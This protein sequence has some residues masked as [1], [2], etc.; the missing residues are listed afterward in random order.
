[1]THK[2]ERL[3]R[4]GFRDFRLRLSDGG[5]KLQVT[6]EQFPLV[7]TRREDILAA[8]SPLFSQVVLDLSPRI[9]VD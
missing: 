5:G 7:Q 2:E 3:A 9:S 8:L 1:M 6:R 4:L